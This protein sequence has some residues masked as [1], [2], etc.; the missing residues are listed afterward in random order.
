MKVEFTAQQIAD[1]LGGNVEGD[2]EAKLSTFCKI[3]EGHAGG[4]SFLANPRYEPYLY[5]CKAT[6]VLVNQDFVP[7]QAISNLTLI[8]VPDAYAALAT[9]MQMVDAASQKPPMGVDAL[10]FVHPSV[11]L[12]SDCYVGPFAYVGKGAK[13]A[14]G[15][16]IHPH[17]YIGE[18]VTIGADSVLY[19]H[20]VVYHACRIGARCIVHAGA[21]IGAD[22]FGFAPAED[23]YHKIPQLGT[24]EIADD[25]EIGANTCIDRAAMG[26]TK[27]ERGVKLDNLVQVAHNCSVGSHTVMAAQVGLAGSSHVGEWCQFGGQAGLSGHLKVGNKVSLGGQ[28]G[29]LGDIAEGSVMLGTPAMPA[30]EMLR[31]AALMRRLPEMYSKLDQL[32]KIL[33]NKTKE[34]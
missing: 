12:P 30:R 28:T 4:L 25:V 34:S 16:R 2:A 7:S 32:E 3:E 17:T 1:L 24:V 29:V 22:G 15:C 6:A 13:I 23:G 9:L 31:I 33:S 20:V 11:E 19:P 21:V 10:A 26:S 27:I 5:E 8:R 18:D 14:P